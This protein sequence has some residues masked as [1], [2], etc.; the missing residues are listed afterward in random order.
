M[1]GRLHEVGIL[2]SVGIGKKQ[3]WGGLLLEII[4]ITLP[5]LM[6]SYGGSRLMVPILNRNLL[7]DLPALAELGE[8]Q[9]QT[10]SFA[11]YGLVYGLILLIVL[12]TAYLST[13][14][15]IRLKP[16]QI[17]SKMS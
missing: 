7:A 2:L 8:Q 1:R 16:K 3:I 5:A 15:T 10:M 13:L 9:L 11:M 4:L 12:A 14:L 17:L 6:V